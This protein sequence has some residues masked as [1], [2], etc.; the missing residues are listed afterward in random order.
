MG[1]P[2]ADENQHDAEEFLASLL[3]GLRGDELRGNRSAAW[4][5][6]GGQD[7]LRVTHVDRI[8]GFVQETR[9]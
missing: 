2:F 5:G 8:C 9:S 6:G 1:E 7:D 3:D 4:N